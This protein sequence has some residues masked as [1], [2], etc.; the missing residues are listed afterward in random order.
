MSFGFPVAETSNLTSRT[1]D[2]DV[3]TQRWR[4][5]ARILREV[6]R[7]STALLRYSYNEQSSA[8]RSRGTSSDFANHLLTVGFR[9][10]FEPI[11]VW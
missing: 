1:F 3:D 8:S 7:N 11:K 4:V 6:G 9:Y 5:A 10:R 2:D